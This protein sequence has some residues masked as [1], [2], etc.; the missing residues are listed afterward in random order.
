MMDSDDGNGPKRIAFRH[1]VTGAFY[2]DRRECIEDRRE[3]P[4]KSGPIPL[5]EH[6]LR[7]LERD[8]KIKLPLCCTKCGRMIWRGQ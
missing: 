5:F 4:L 2:C 7:I 8:R 1:D 3:P 6:S